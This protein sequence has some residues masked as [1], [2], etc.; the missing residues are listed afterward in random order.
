M[1][2]AIAGP[3]AAFLAQYGYLALVAL[4]FVSTLGAP[5]PITGVLISLG[6]LSA[7]ARGPSL[8]VVA[9][10][11]LGATVAGDVV[12]YSA[13]WAG[14]VPLLRWAKRDPHSHRARALT[15][16][17]AALKRYG[18][19][20]LF[21]SRFLFTAIATPVTVLVGATRLRRRAFLGWDIAGKAIYVLGNLLIG[22]L[23]GASLGAHTSGAVFWWS[24]VAVAVLVPLAT[25][26]A[27]R[28]VRARLPRVEQEVR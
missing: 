7:V 3:F 17:E 12:A 24:I 22:R 6:A 23:F 19:L 11:A 15:R 5:L 26:L 18:P 4:V 21:L 20:I 25:A 8:V 14:G 27:A 16:A 1:G 28:L 2:P 9:L 10:L 13:G